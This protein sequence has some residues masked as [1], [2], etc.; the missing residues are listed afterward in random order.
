MAVPEDSELSVRTLGVGALLGMVFAGAAVYAGTK[1]GIVDG[2]NIPAA[3]LAFAILTAITRTRARP[4]DGNIV[5]TVSS[6]AAM[7]AITSGLVGPIAAMA[8]DGSAPAPAGVVVW[9]VAVGVLGSLMA[10]PLRAAFIVRGTLPF[11]SGAATAEVLDSVYSGA[12]AAGGRIRMLALGAVLAAAIAFARSFAGWI[13]ELTVIPLTVGA[14]PAAAIYMGIG[15]SPLLVGIGYLAGARVAIALVLGGVIAWFVIA[16]Q[17]VAAN[18]AAPDYVSLVTW[19]LWPGAGLMVGGTVGGIVSAWRGL[20]AGLREVRASHAAAQHAAHDAAH[21]K[22]R[23][24]RGHVVAMVIAALAIIVLGVLV[25][26]VHPAVTMLGLGLSIVLCAAAARAMGETDNTPA[27]PLGGFAQLVVGAVA[28]GGIAAPLS[29]GGVVNGTLMH[30]AM[31]LQNWKTGVLVGSR[32]RPQ[33]VA[34]L[35]GVVVGGVTCALAFELIRGSYGL[36]NDVMPAPAAQSWKATAELVQHGVSALPAGAPVAAAIAFVAGIALALAGSTRWLAWVPS[37]VALGMAFILPP[38][39]SLT[40]AIGGCVRWLVERRHR[41]WAATHG[42]A[43]VSG[44]IAGEALAG[45]AIAALIIA[46]VSVGGH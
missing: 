21:D 24:T 40:I 42:I 27:G 6:S 25:F 2:G 43:L 23:T 31:L 10:I 4:H 16:P 18:I 9:G 26:D 34:Q 11:P 44:L 1:T 36:G 8:L 12:A 28:P 22:F 35:V 5:Q 17:V 37:P 30:S 19:L 13:P 14:V 20:R 39:L 7:M 32:P 46:G 29:A 41:A 33:L 45:L 3:L 15:W 38:Y